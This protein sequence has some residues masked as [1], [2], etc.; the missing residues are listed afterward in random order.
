VTIFG[1]SYDGA[2]E[3]STGFYLGQLDSDVGTPNEAMAA[4]IKS[5]WATFFGAG[6]NMIGYRWKTDGVKIAHLKTDG[7]TDL[8]NVV[9]S[10]FTTPVAGPSTGIGF[11]PQVSVVATLLAD[12][13]RGLA[14]KGRM[15]IPGV[16]QGLDATGHMG[17]PYPQTLA[18]NL[19]AF[20]ADIQS[21]FDVVGQL[22]N[23]SQGRIVA[24][25][26]GPLNR[27]VTHV[28]VGNVYDTQRRRR[29]QLSEVYSTD[30]I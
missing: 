11:P 25:G 1:N 26:T 7:K 3:W 23:A 27:A 6:A 13:G 15:F 14:G 21:S 19:A 16:Q 10:Y 22:I 17:S 20:F 8:D 5:A 28:R 4:A 18:T 9:T 29:N 24:G 30:E 12:N 2:E